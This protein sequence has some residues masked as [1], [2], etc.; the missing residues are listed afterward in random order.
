[1]DAVFTLRPYK[2]SDVNFIQNSWGSSYYKGADFPD[3]LSPKEFN[4]KHRPIREE[5]LANP[6]AA[7]IIACDAL[8][9]DLILGWILIEKSKGKGLKLHYLYIK[10]AFKGEGISYELLKKALPETPILITHMTDRA[11][12]IIR[13]KKEFFK[14][15]AYANDLIMVRDKYLS[16]L[17]RED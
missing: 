6:N 11:R 15:F 10:E 8:D 14:D 17:P 4:A 16:A 2:E 3:Y 7:C 9:E 13:K 1:M 12:K 5:L